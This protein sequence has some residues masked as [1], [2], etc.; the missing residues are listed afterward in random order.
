LVAGNFDYVEEGLLDVTHIRFFTRK[1]VNQL[2]EQTGYRIVRV[3]ANY[4]PRISADNLTP[5]ATC[6]LD[7]PRLSVKNATPD[8]F[9]EFRT[10]QF[11]VD[12]TPA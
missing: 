6:N 5:G 1:S 2:F 8:E 9:D 10:I 12:A 7:L 11:L 4:D 3:G